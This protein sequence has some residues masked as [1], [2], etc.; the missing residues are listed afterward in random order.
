MATTYLSPGVYVEEVDAG[1][2]PI[3]GVGT[4]ITAFVGIT[5]EASL[6]SLNPDTGLKEPVEDR[7][8]K[9]TLVTSWMQFN[10][11]FG[12][13]VDGAYLPDAVYGYYSNGGGPCYVTS[14]RAMDSASDATAA[15][16][17][18]PASKGNSFTVTAKSAGSGGNSLTV[19]ISDDKDNSGKATGSFT[20]SVGGETKSGLSIPKGCYSSTVQHLNFSFFNGIIVVGIFAFR[21]YPEFI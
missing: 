2:K 15:S 12:G 13:F 18:V 1:V 7:L 4:S 8:N 11:V 19:E 3:G 6:K 14:L 17:T 9:T 20:M 21:F 10:E 5:A 16:A